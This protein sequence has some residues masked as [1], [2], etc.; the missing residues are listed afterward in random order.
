MTAFGPHELV[1]RLRPTG[2]PDLPDASGR[3]VRALSWFAIVAQVVFVAGWIVG[4]LLEGG[5]SPV[6]M[7]VSD[8]GRHGAANP[9]IFDV[10][11]VIWGFGF[12]A[13][14]LAMAPALRSRPWALVAPALFVLAGICAI[15]DAPLRLDCATPVSALCRARED[16]GTL[17]WHHYGHQWAAFGVQVALAL[18]PFALARST[19]PS[20]LAQLLLGGGIV[21]ALLVAA[22]FP[23]DFEAAGIAGLWQRAEL[24][25]VHVWVVMCA[26][27]LLFEAR[28][29]PP[30]G[31]EP[32]S[33][34]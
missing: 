17:S 24:L 21:I 32:G 2:W 12:V 33:T 7:Y 27:A 5:Y 31:V 25:I 26:A 13:L 16:T 18:T 30:P 14:A 6:R 11:V 34:A 22:T 15:L 20:R 29:A 4:W 10:A 8:L 9:W 1:E 23:V 19:W 28:R 3:R